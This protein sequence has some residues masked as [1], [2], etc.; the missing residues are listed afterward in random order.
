M[1]KCP[2]CTYNITY[3]KLEC[4]GIKEIGLAADVLFPKNMLVALDNNYKADTTKRV[5]GSFSTIV[6]DWNDIL[7]EFNMQ[8][9]AIKGFEK[10]AIAVDRAVFDFSDVKNSPSVVFP[11]GYENLIPGNEQLWRGVYVNKLQIIYPK[12]L[13]KGALPNG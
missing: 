6:T 4:G 7:A 5:K 1:K 9:F 3:A 8:P 2:R 10:F 12:N 13:K 11:V